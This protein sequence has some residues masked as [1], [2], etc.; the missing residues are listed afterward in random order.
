L[1]NELAKLISCK[2]DQVLAISAKTGEGVEELLKK[3]FLEFLNH[4][5]VLIN[6]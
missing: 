3:L 6:H 4:L 5:A 2:E 1:K